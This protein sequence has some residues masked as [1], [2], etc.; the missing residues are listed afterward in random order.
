M[1]ALPVP[2]QALESTQ[3]PSVPS[4]QFSVSVRKIRKH[5]K[6][7]FQF[8]HSTLQ[9]GLQNQACVVNLHIHIYIYMSVL[10]FSI[11]DQ[12]RDSLPLPALND[13][14]GSGSLT[15]FS[16]SYLV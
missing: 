16:C 14:S 3:V 5:E 4:F 9:D 2:S 12:Y 13:F 8:H 7:S 6:L 1:T 15:D 11:F 10:I